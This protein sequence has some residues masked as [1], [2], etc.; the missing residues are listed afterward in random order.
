MTGAATGSRPTISAQGS[1]TNI[2]MD[3]SA[4]GFSRIFMLSNGA[5]NAEFTYGNQTAGV[6]GN[7]VKMFGNAAGTAPVYS[8][9]GTDTNID[10]TLTPK[11]TGLVR[12]G[13][14]TAGAP[15]ATG[16]ISIKA[17]DG[18]TYKVLVGT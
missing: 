3:I 2:N 16:Y 1:D 11:G 4:K 12:F 5:R 6:N 13:T 17:A 15:Q 14:Y 18:T 8:V 10:L 9:D 7:Y